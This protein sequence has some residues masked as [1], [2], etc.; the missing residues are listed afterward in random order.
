MQVANSFPRTH[1]IPRIRSA[2]ETLEYCAQTR[3]FV[4]FFFFRTHDR[5]PGKKKGEKRERET[6][7]RD[8]AAAGVELDDEEAPS[9]ELGCERPEPLDDR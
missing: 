7:A 8:G 3:A 1:G 2:G 9:G 4:Q 5:T 6:L